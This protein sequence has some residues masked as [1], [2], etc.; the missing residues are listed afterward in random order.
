MEMTPDVNVHF[1]DMPAT[2][3]AFVKSNSDGSYSVI[4]NSRLTQERLLEAYQH[5]LH[6]ITCGDYDRKCNADFIELYAHGC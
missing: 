6:H 1:M 5:E 3:P 4:L 2:I